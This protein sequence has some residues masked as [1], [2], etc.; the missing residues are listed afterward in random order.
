VRSNT[1]ASQPASLPGPPRALSRS[2]CA[3][4]LCLCMAA[5]D[6]L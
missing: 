2:A 3:H 5:L 1:T 4:S 6:V